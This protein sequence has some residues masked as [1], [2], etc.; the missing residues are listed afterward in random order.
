[1]N[2]IRWTIGHHKKD[3]NALG[4]APFFFAL[5]NA[6]EWLPGLTQQ[7]LA[8]SRASDRAGTFSG[9][10]G[11]SPWNERKGPGSVRYSGPMQTLFGFSRLLGGSL[12]LEEKRKI[13]VKSSPRHRTKEETWGTP[14]K[15][16][17]HD[18]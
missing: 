12:T 17:L 8:K 11:G 7:S 18:L 10:T 2:L 3:V 4:K 14:G 9:V 15:R 6:K 13:E 16:K 1:M 5:A